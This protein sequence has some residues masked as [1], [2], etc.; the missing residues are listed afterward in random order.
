MHSVTVGDQLVQLSGQLHALAV[1]KSKYTSEYGLNHGT[2]PKKSFH[3]SK[4]LSFAL[5][6]DSKYAW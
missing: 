3:G 6:F 1:S 5:I 2:Q 4:F